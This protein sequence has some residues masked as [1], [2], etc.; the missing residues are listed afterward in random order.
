M[1]FLLKAKKRNEINKKLIERI[2]LAVTEV[3]DCAVCSYVHTKIALEAGLNNEE[4]KNLLMGNRSDVP[5]NEL[6]AILFAEHYADSRAK[7]SKDAWERI[8]EVYGLSKAKGILAAIRMIM[9][10]NTVGIA[11]NSFINRFKGKADKRS[12]IFYELGIFT[13][14][15]IFA[16]FVLIHSIFSVIFRIPLISF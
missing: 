9:I 16:P 6:A 10:G 3:N 12:N 7:P 8:V 14:L 15:I 5:D 11:S 1:R 13:S 2:N 4:I